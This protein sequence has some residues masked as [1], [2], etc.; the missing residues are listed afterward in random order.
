MLIALTLIATALLVIAYVAGSELCLPGAR[1]ALRTGNMRFWKSTCLLVALGEWAMIVIG[2]GFLLIAEHLWHVFNG[3]WPERLAGLLAAGMLLGATVWEL[4]VRT[5]SNIARTMS[6]SLDM[7]LPANGV[8]RE[9]YASEHRL[10]ESGSRAERE[11]ALRHI[12]HEPRP[13]GNEKSL[14]PAIPERRGRHG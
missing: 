9:I 12:L 10:L 3:G 1:L 11:Q 5:Q 14:K 4:A 6:R 7:V 13:V 8:Q 2:L